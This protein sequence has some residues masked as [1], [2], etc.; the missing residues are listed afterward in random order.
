MR[1]VHESK[2]HK[3]NAF[4][5]LTY[6]DDHIPTRNN[7]N[8]RDFQLF[9][10]RLRKKTAPITP[11]YYMCGEYGE[12]NERPH[13]HACIFGYDFPDKTYWSTSE[14]G[15][16]IYRSEILEK[17]WPYGHSST[18]QLTFESAAYVARY[19]LKKHTGHNA[20]QY[21]T[22]QDENGTYKLTPEFGHMSLKP[23][24]G[25]EWYKRYKADVHTHDYVVINGRECRPPRY[26]DEILKRN[27]EERYDDIKENRYNRAKE[28]A[29]NN[30]E[31]RL[32]VR[33][34]V[35]TEKLKFLKRDKL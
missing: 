15:G 5:T 23:G 32:R 16:K 4:I 34:T 22:R 35:T 12:L 24:I 26:Y 33:E 7:L 20:E 11:R 8:Y 31:E 17:L 3:Q 18:A 27:D 9:F 30:T 6:D 19:C 29:D 25:A 13:Y 1:C 2:L 28:Y 10:K 14:S 21:Y